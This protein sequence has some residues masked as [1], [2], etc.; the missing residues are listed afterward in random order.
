MY[1]SLLH[2]KAQHV[3]LRLFMW[4]LKKLLTMII[5]S[6]SPL[7]SLLVATTCISSSTVAVHGGQ[8]YQANQAAT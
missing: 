4:E 6:V 7:R 3:V 8:T 1:R 5:D 2:H